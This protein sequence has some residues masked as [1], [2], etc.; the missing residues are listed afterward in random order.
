MCASS[1]SR[2]RL[3]TAYRAPSN[4]G[5]SSVRSE[6]LL[7][8]RG[9]CGC[10]RHHALFCAALLLQLWHRQDFDGTS[11]NV[12]RASWARASLHAACCALRS[13]CSFCP[14]T[15]RLSPA[16]ACTYVGECELHADQP[17]HIPWHPITSL[18]SPRAP[19]CRSTMHIMHALRSSRQ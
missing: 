9:P 5:R 6:A 10:R 8:G 1:A 3:P 7:D 19:F 2:P 16:V 18:P 17:W 13:A 11:C 15:G 14:R 4:D 12:A